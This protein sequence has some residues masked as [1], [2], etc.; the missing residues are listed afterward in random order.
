[1]SNCDNL[2]EMQIDVMREIGNIGAGNACTALSVLLGTTVDMS[3]PSV[4][5]LDYDSTSDYLGGSSDII[6]GI[7]IEVNEDLEGLMFHVVKKPFAER[8]INTFYAKT[9]ESLDQLDDMDTSVLNEMG[10]ITSGAYANSIATLTGLFVNIG[11]PVQSCSTVGEL[12]KIPFSRFGNA[13]EKIL[14]IDEEYIIGTEK[15]TSNV[16]FILENNSLKKLFEKLGVQI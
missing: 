14:V 9:L 3:V 11:A 15:I 16:L 1:M 2:N 6:L 4:K 13:S 12:L 7:E 5:I 8:I 10:N